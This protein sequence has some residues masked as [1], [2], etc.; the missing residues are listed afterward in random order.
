MQSSKKKKLPLHAEP[1]LNGSDAG[2]ARVASMSARMD[3]QHPS[4]IG[5]SVSS[6]PRHITMHHETTVGRAPETLCA[7]NVVTTAHQFCSAEE[8]YRSLGCAERHAAN[9]LRLYPA[10]MLLVMTTARPIWRLP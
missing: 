3:D 8:D 10:T 7:F 1:L 9:G 2:L 4:V 6:T 5:D